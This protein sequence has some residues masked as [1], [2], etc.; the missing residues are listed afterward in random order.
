MKRNLIIIL[1]VVGFIIGVVASGYIIIK[2]AT[3]DEAVKNRLLS[4]VRNFGEAKIDRAHLDFLEGIII[5][6]LSFTGTSEDVQG[7]SIRIPKIILKHDPQSLIKGQLNISNAVII[8]PELTI[9]KPSDI[10]SLLDAIKANLGK[11]EMPVYIDALRHGV[12]IRDLKVHINEDK[13]TSRPEVKLSGIDIIFL[14]YAGSFKDIRIKG[15]IDDE[16]LGNYSF[17]IRLR[18]EVPSLDV[19]VYAKNLELDEAFLARF[20]Y[21]GKMLWDDYKPIGKINVS[22]TAN[23]N[24]QDNQKKMDYAININLN[25][26][27]ALYTDWPFLIHDLN[28]DIELNPKKLYLKGIA[29]YIKNGNHTSQAEFRGEFDLYGSQKTFVMNIPNLFVNEDLLKNIPG[30]GEQVWLKAHPTGFVDLAF[31]YNKNEHQDSCNFLIV[32][33]KGL[34]INPADFPLP[35]SYLNGQFKICNN[36]ILFKNTSGFI[37]CG[38]QSIFTEMNGVYD[39]KSERKIFNL[40]VPNLFI[41]KA[42]LQNLPDKEIGEKL[43]NTI[44]PRGKADVIANFQGFKEKKDNNYSIEINLKDC[45]ITV[46]KYKI[47]IWG[48][49]GRLE[50]NKKRLVSKRINAKC[51]GGN[52]E[53]HVL[54]NRETNPYRYKGELN[55]SRINIEELAHHIQT[56][57]LWSGLLYG[58]ITYQGS[59]TDIEDFS[60]NGQFNVEDGYLSDVPII[61]SVF[62]FLSLSLPKKETFHSAQAKFLVRNGLIHINSSKVSSDTVELNGRGDI[63]LNGDLRLNIVAGFDKNFFSDIPLVGKLFDFI[64]G[65]VRKQLTMVEIKGNFFKPEIHSV[66]FKPI[67]R[68]IKNVFDLLP[69]DEH[70]IAIGTEEKNKK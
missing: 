18:P 17:T 8:A 2:R 16:F 31:Q 57:K 56:Q 51:Y 36:I 46:S 45:S 43:L 20:P 23:F 7:K 40:R 24:N 65:G 27:K 4:I 60:A 14:P 37:R 19:E 29:G 6:N 55:L 39:T 42:F 26:I 5:D 63:S 32:D 70:D 3:S 64:V 59:S 49:E 30:V 25:G 15:N 28:G 67:T 52:L 38:D 58:R 66:P 21:I 54:I 53:G 44:N 13:Q 62:N 9:E 1:I 69:N 10:W 34:E 47:P 50:L 68:S 12:E 35:I 11:A 61:L 41:T 22:C 33:C 48:I